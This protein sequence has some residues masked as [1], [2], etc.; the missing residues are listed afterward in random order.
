V[1]EQAHE[2]QFIVGDLQQHG[3]NLPG[4]FVA[5]GIIAKL[6]PTWRGFVTSLKHKRQNICV[7]DLLAFLDVEEKAPAK[8]G[9]PKTFEGQSNANFMRTVAKRN[10]KLKSF[11]PPT[12]RK[13][14][15]RSSTCLMLNALSV[16]RLGTLPKS[17]QR[18]RAR[19][20][21]KGRITLPTWLLVRLHQ[22]G[23]VIH[24]LF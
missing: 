10:G 17:A 21:S 12:S 23:M 16:G 18:G 13:S 22:Q 15:R 7:Q 14:S 3:H 11:R 6:P 2:I 1:V 24:I 4:R 8:D 19:K 5:G 20:I 9:P